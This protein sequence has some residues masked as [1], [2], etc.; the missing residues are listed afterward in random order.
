MGDKRE[1]VQRYPPDV[2][3]RLV[4]SSDIHYGRNNKS[5]MSLFFNHERKD[6]LKNE[7]THLVLLSHAPSGQYE[8]QLN[9]SY[10]YRD[11]DKRG[12]IDILV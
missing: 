3:L 11:H 12:K 8:D 10:H 1:F 6:Y 7:K 9:D 5:R 2:L 4:A